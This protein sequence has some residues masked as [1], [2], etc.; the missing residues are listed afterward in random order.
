MA[1]QAFNAI[2]IAFW[3]PKIHYSHETA[4]WGMLMD[5]DRQK[6]VQIYKDVD[7]RCCQHCPYRNMG[8]CCKDLCDN[9]I[10]NEYL[11]TFCYF[12][13]LNLLWKENSFFTSKIKWYLE[14]QWYK[15]FILR[16]IC[17]DLLF[18]Q[19]PHWEQII[20][21]WIICIW[22]NLRRLLVSISCRS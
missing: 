9:I 12:R 19:L 3:W 1:L 20:T 2:G 5:I 17:V 21:Y 10:V 7:S 22:T 16:T 4:S 14:I 6:N 8:G 13:L 18:E 15:H 11:F